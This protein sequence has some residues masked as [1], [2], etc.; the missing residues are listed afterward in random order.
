[1]IMY[2]NTII[3]FKQYYNTNYL[4]KLFNKII[5]IQKKEI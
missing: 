1:M 4:I 3:I 5:H 2:I